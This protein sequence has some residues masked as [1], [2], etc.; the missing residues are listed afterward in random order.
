MQNVRLSKK[1]TV[2]K[3]RQMEL[4]KDRDGIVQFIRA[5]FTERYFSPV[6]SMRSPHGFLI[7]AVSCL[8]IEAIQ[9]FR[10]GWQ[11]TTKRRDKP[12]RDFFREHQA[13]GVSPHQ[14]D[15]LYDN[16]RSGI[17]HLGE[18][19]RGWRIHRR[20]PAIDFALRTINATRFFK[21]VQRAFDEY[22]EQLIR[23]QW[24]SVIWEKLRTRMNDII[25]SCE[26]PP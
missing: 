13:F 1:T 20:G 11:G 23:A 9:A 17:L 26:S 22:C 10:N 21:E 18:T 5:R 14:A 12:Y 2:A 19:Y 8:L 3:Y 16:V 4:E 24:G 7:M 25:R 6:E 15:D